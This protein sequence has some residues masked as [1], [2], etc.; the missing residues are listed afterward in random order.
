MKF[1]LFSPNQENLEKLKENSL[2]NGKGMGVD[3]LKISNII[4][5]SKVL[6]LKERNENLKKS[7]DIYKVG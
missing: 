4:V 2:E 6:K 7:L 1:T 5:M 3:S